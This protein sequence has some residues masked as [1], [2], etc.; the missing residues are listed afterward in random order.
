MLNVL[1]LM[2][3]SSFVEVVVRSQ[4]QT[5]SRQREPVQL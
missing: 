5:Q 2:Q 4:K 1:Y 3:H